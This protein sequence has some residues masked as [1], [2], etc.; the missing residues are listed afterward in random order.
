MYK[1]IL[2]ASDSTPTGHRG[3]R[4]ACAL[5]KI[6]AAE[7]EILYVVDS[8]VVHLDVNG[9]TDAGE[10][11]DVLHNAGIAALDE[12]RK[13][14]FECGISAQIKL[15][16]TRAASIADVIVQEAR[17]WQAD[18][19]VMGTHSKHGLG[20]LVMGSEADNVLHTSPVPML[21]VRCAG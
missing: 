17:D 3:L 2:V 14:A 13:V 1:R 11:I 18:L 5:A 15:I 4:E 21:L 12:A 16:E 9:I 6:L 19:I 8:H 7:L 10:L 20:S